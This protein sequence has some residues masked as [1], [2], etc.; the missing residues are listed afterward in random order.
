MLSPGKDT[1]NI[2]KA[3]KIILYW[4][5]RGAGFTPTPTQS[6]PHSENVDKCFK[7]LLE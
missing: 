1:S 6:E 7:H 2:M 3:I 5:P 4:V